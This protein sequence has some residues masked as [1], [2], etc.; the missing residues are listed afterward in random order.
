[1]KKKNGVVVFDELTAQIDSLTLYEPTEVVDLTTPEAAQPSIVDAS[2]SGKVL[3]LVLAQLETWSLIGLTYEV[4]REWRE[5]TITALRNYTL[6]SDVAEQYIGAR[7][8]LPPAVIAA[9]AMQQHL[10]WGR[11][12]AEGGFKRVFLCYNPEEDRKEAVSV[13]DLA[14]MESNGNLVISAIC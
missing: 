10:P 1:M 8:L 3:S 13:M 7:S 4:N 11:Y 2:L 9:D 14:E 5:A 6:P 12:L